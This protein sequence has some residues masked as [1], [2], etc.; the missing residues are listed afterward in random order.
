MK[1]FIQGILFITLL[2]PLLDNILSLTNQLTELWCTKIALKSYNYK[3]LMIE[4][5]ETATSAIGFHFDPEPE[6]YDSYEEEDE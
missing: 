4:E 5:E 1:R 3:K 6:K 2:I